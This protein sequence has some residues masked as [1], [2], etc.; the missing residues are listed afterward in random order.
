MSTTRDYASLTPESMLVRKACAEALT[1]HGFPIREAT[2]STMATRGGG[3]PF[4]L[5]NRRVIYNWG[6]ALEWARG[7]VSPAAPTAS[8][9]RKVIEQL[10]A[11]GA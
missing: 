6:A 7:K 1:A 8:E 4:G 2:L 11:A 3:P 5:F 9:R 10:A